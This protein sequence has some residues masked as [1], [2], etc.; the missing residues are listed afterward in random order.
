MVFFLCFWVGLCIAT[1]IV[2]GNRGRGQL[3]WLLLAI[4]LGPVALIMVLVSKPR[5]VELESREILNGGAVRCPYCAELVRSQA[6]VCK[7]CG[8]DIVK[9]ESPGGSRENEFER[10]LR[11]QVPPVINPSSLEREDLRKAFDYARGSDGA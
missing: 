2:A 7:H 11:A 5:L 6:I 1:M 10:W 3:S 4:L 9:L 8:R